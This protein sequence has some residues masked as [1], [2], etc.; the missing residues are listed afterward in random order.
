MLRPSVKG[1]AA[2]TG[3]VRMFADSKDR[4]GAFKAR[5]VRVFKEMGKCSRR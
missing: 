2:A 3:P 4:G 5:A 1:L